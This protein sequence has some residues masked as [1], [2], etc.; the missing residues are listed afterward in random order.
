VDAIAI[1][2]QHNYKGTADIA[3]AIGDL[4]LPSVSLPLHPTGTSGNPPDP[5]EIYL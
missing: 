3:K 2:I 4:V 5:G 1:H